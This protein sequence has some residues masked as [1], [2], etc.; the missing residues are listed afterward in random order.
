M[1]KLKILLLIIPIM[2]LKNSCSE[3]KYPIKIGNDY[4]VDFC[5]LGYNTISDSNRTYIIY[6]E[7]V[8]WNYDSVFIIAKQKP[9]WEIFD[10]LRAI[11]PRNTVEREHLYHNTEKYNYWIV[12][13]RI[14][15]IYDYENH[16]YIQN[17]VNGPYS[18]EEYCER[19]K[20]LGVP[21]SLKLIETER[22]KKYNKFFRRYYWHTVKERGV[23]E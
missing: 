14:E 12:D 19:R 18:Y 6:S 22:R 9:C 23:V 10:S 7:V 1:R 20:E 15:R 11:Y 17:S 8:A 5:H 2:L 4:F 3:S 21:D 16:L 13:K